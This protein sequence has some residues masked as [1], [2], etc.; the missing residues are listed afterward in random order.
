MVQALEELAE[1]W[2]GVKESHQEHGQPVP[3]APS[4]KEPRASLHYRLC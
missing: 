3:V 1:A 2:E 4:R